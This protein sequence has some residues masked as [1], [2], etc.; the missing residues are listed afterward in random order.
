ML[1]LRPCIAC[2]VCHSVEAFTAATSEVL[3]GSLQ[4]FS[5]LPSTL[6]TIYL[7]LAY[8][9]D[10]GQGQPAQADYLSWL[11]LS[12]SFAFLTLCCAVVALLVRP[13]ATRTYAAQQASG[14]LRFR[15]AHVVH[16][17][18]D[19]AATAGQRFQYERVQHSLKALYHKVWHVVRLF[20]HVTIPRIS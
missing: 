13:I 9:W 3:F 16:N 8:L 7:S 19:I 4:Y 18:L 2:R 15:Y 10:A 11:P 5:S 17:A 1:V 20:L 6:T 12:F 14:D